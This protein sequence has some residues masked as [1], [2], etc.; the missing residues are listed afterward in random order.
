M[1]AF[2]HVCSRLLA[3][4]CVFASAFACVCQ[5]LSAFV[6]VCS[7]LLTPPLLRPPLRDTD[8]SEL[9]FSILVRLGLPTVLW[10]LLIFILFER[11][12]RIASNLRFTTHC[13]PK[14]DLQKKRGFSSETLKRFSGV[15]KRVFIKRVVL[16][17]VPWN[18]NRN[19]GIFGCSPVTKTGTRVR[20]HVPPERELERGY[21]RQNHPFTKP[22]FSPSEIR[23]SSDAC[24]SGH[25]S[26]GLPELG[27]WLD[28]YWPTINMS[29]F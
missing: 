28:M 6:C 14:R 4:A 7:H 13:A 21:V 1:F 24:K 11:F 5:R 10:P 3:F 25:L 27:Q 8:Y 20:S 23:E 17:D 12:A 2:V 9:G 16:A 22:P 19:K 29:N 26:S 18:E 15:D